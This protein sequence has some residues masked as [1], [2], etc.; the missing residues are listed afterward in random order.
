MTADALTVHLRL[1]WEIVHHDK[2]EG[3][4][5]AGAG[6]PMCKLP[7][8][9]GRNGHTD[10]VNTLNACGGSPKRSPESGWT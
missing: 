4:G 9:V 7:R 2:T 1:S 6:D 8:E 10:A 5:L 3:L